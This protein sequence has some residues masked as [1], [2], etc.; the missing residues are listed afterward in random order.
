MSIGKA[1]CSIFC[2]FKI[3][4]EIYAKRDILGNQEY[5]KLELSRLEYISE[6][7]LR[8]KGVFTIF[9]KE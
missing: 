4:K 3:W 1:V 2:R 9:L 7:Y 6:N 8:N 5:I